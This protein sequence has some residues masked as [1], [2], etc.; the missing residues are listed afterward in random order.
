[1]L[2]PTALAA[3]RRVLSGALLASHPGPASPHGCVAMHALQVMRNKLL[4]ELAGPA[5]A[6]QLAAEAL[7]LRYWKSDAL[8]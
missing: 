6:A 8:G 4:A 7:S 5:S 1:M 2:P 3:A